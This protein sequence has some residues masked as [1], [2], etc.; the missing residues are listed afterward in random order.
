MPN[1]KINNRQLPLW[2][3]AQGL[4]QPEL[5]KIG[6]EMYHRHQQR[7]AARAAAAELATPTRAELEL[8]EPPERGWRPVEKE[9]ELGV[10]GPPDIAA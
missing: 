1:E 8:C 2:G 10:L 3:R 4:T 6:A 9:E 5:G 7:D